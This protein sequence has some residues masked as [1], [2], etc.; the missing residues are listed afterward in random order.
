MFNSTPL[1]FLNP[2]HD[3]SVEPCQPNP[4]QP[5]VGHVL[6]LKALCKVEVP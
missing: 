5:M 2:Q 4:T 3:D 6:E 1:L